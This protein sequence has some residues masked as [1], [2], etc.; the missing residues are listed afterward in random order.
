MKE[1]YSILEDEQARELGIMPSIEKVYAGEPVE[2]PLYSYTVFDTLEKLDFENTVPMPRTCWIQTQ[3]FPLKDEAGRVTSS[4]FMSMDIT[5]QKLAEMALQES[6]S[7]FRATFEQAAVGI[8][9]VSIDGYFLRINQRFCDIV[10]YNQGEM[11]ELTF[12]DIT[13]PDDMDADVAEVQRLLDGEKTTYSMEK[14]YIHKDKHHVWVNLTVS[15]VRDEANAPA[16]FVAVV[17]D[18]SERKKAEN[19][20]IESEERFRSLV[21]QSPVSIQIHSPDGKIIEANQAFA[22]L[23]GLSKEALEEVYEKFNVLKDEQLKEKGL[24]SFLEKPFQGETVILP[25]Y[26]YDGVDTLRT[27]DFEKPIARRCWVQTMGFPM[28]DTEGK[29]KFVVFMCQD[30]TERKQ[31]EK[32]IDDMRYYTDHLIKTANVMIV[33]LDNGGSGS[34]F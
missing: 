24:M 32:K 4:V 20:L 16:W 5:E 26:E 19:A 10:G 13:H 29:V 34:A 11:L 30:I 12:K 9:H 33:S 23:Y 17:D 27:L 28:L 8:A 21:E 22:N 15:L 18:I 25:P 6:E 1:K 14:R 31:A 7:R 2:F 3:G